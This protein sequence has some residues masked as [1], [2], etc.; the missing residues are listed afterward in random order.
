[1]INS[2]RRFIA[3]ESAGGIVLALAAIVALVVS[4]SALAKNAVRTTQSTTTLTIPSGAGGT[5]RIGLQVFD[6]CG[7]ASTMTDVVTV[8]ITP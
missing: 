5:F 8:G 1:M 4:N 7:L 3:S 2:L 6:A